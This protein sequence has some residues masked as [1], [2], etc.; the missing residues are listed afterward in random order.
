MK[1]SHGMLLVLISLLL[2]SFVFAVDAPIDIDEIEK[3][4]EKIEEGLEDVEDTIDDPGSILKKTKAGE[5]IDKINLWFENYASWLKLVFGMVPEISWLFA[6]NLYFWLLFLIILVLN[7]SF[8]NSFLSE[9]KARIAGVAIFIILVFTKIILNMASFVHLKLQFIYEYGLIGVLILMTILAVLA[10]FFPKAFFYLG[11]II[12]K[13]KKWQEEHK[14][15]VD[16]KAIET[17]VEGATK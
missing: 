14:K 2:V 11:Q 9:G 7:Q 10:I 16:R 6:F 8:L 1:K 17:I 3:G 13:S 12:A 5:R 15:K 4:A